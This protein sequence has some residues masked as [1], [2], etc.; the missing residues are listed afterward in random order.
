MGEFELFFEKATGHS[1]Y[2]YQRKLAAEPIQSRLIHVPTGAGKTAAAIVAWLWR[3]KE[4]PSGTPR[5]LVYCLPMRVL[6]EQTRDID[7][8]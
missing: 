1:P 2:P 3:R 7:A 6:V 4:N 8:E 5:R